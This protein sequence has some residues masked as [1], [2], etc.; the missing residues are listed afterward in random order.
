MV[1]HPVA[2]PRLAYWNRGMPGK[3]LP[4]LALYEDDQGAEAP[5]KD[6]TLECLPGESVVGAAHQEPRAVKRGLDHYEVFVRQLVLAAH[7]DAPGLLL[8]L[9]LL[10]PEEG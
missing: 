10:L 7:L 4:A 5:V 2:W 8:L 9:L 3:Q 1:C 6:A